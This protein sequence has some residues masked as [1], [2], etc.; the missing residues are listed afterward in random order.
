MNLTLSK[1]N[2]IPHL[3]TAL[4]GPLPFIE[5]CFLD[6][7]VTIEAWLRTQW[8]KT[9]APMTSS[10]DI[11]NAAHKLAV[12]DT[13]LFPAGFNNL[14]RD[15]LPLCVQAAQTMMMERYPWCKKILIVPENHT[16]N[17]FYFSSLA[18]LREIFTKAGYEVRIGSLLPDLQTPYSVPESM[19]GAGNAEM[20]LEPIIRKGEVIAIEGFQPCMILLNND[21]A[22]GIPAILEGISQ[23]IEPSLHLGWA[24][25]LKSQHFMHYEQVCEEFATLLNVDPWLMNPYFTACDEVDFMKQGGADRLVSEVAKILGKIQQKYTE[26]NIQQRPFVVVKADA[27]T[28]G[29]GVMM[30]QD[31]EQLRQLNRKQRTH[32]AAT[33]GGRK[34]DRVIIQEGVYT[35]ETVG[36]ENAVAEPVVYLLGSCVIGGFYR[37]HT[38]RGHD[39]NLN[40]PGM[41]FEPLVFSKACNIPDCSLPPDHIP[42]RFYAYGVMARL[43][44]LAAGREVASLK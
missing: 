17:P 11:R 33:K 37:V 24:T 36:E 30:V 9:P 35:F 5:K 40:A 3:Q 41:H 10:V 28:Y 25:R 7:Q 14:N 8:Q 43:A 39:E 19:L 18:M 13:N 2:P 42:N 12:V 26:Y 32:M 1:P 21:L 22:S 20:L 23:P 27:G 16:R 29:M 38:G 15:F 34:L 6:N 4:S 31:A 44:A